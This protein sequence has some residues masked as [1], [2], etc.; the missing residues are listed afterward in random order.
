VIHTHI[1]D[2]VDFLKT[3]L[4]QCDYIISNP[5]YSKKTEVF[6]RLME[7]GKPFA[8]LCNFQGMFDNKKR[9][10]IF[11][12]K[13]TQLMVLYPRVGFY[14]DEVAISKRVPFQSAYVCKDI[15]KESLV[16]EFCKGGS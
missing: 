9:F 5:P 1:D 4:P 8:M 6:A 10:E 13:G 14:N 12:D 11:K 7:F 2:G 15:L 16:F 3:D